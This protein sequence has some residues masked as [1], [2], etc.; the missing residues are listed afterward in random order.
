LTRVRHSG[1]KAPP[2]RSRIAEQQSE[3]STVKSSTVRV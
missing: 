1:I 3:S 2:R